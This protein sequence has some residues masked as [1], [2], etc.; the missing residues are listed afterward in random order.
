[1]RSDKLKVQKVLSLKVE[2]VFFLPGNL[3]DLVAKY[4]ITPILFI[5]HLSTSI[6]SLNCHFQD[7]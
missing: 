6:K 2:T 7:I 3:T 1:M 5:A 4:D